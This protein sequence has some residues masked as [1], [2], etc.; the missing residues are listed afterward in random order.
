MSDSQRRADKMRLRLRKKLRRK[1]ILF[2]DTE[3]DCETVEKKEI[4]K[5]FMITAKPYSTI[6]EVEQDLNNQIQ[7]LV[8]DGWKINS[9]RNIFFRIN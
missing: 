6:E 2:S 4:R 8:N 1:N 3:S 9:Q 5:Q 7:T